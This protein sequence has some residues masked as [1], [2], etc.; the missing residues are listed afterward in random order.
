VPVHEFSERGR[1]VERSTVDEILDMGDEEMTGE[2][3]LFPDWSQALQ[4]TFCA[5]DAERVVGQLFDNEPACFERS[6]VIAMSAS[7]LD[8]ENVRRRGTSRM[9][10]SGCR[11]ASAPSWLARK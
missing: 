8:S 5:I 6:S 10:K 7:R 4:I 1:V 3:G 2:V 11:A 9:S